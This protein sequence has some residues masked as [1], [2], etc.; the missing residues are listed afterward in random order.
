MTNYYP[1]RILRL[2]EAQYY[3]GMGR[4]LFDREIRP[5]LP[6]IQMGNQGI[7]FDRL[8]L[9]HAL[10]EYKTR[11]VRVKEQPSWQD[12]NSQGCSGTKK[13]EKVRLT[14]ASTGSVE[15]ATALQQARKQKQK[16]NITGP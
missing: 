6:E 10:D 15:F 11:N 14:N 3:A 4:T 16:R 9:D 2:P 8:D 5:Y 7:G 12:T 1:P 13:Q